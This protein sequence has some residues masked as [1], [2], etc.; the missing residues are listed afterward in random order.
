MCPYIFGTLEL[1]LQTCIPKINLGLEKSLGEKK[2]SLNGFGSDTIFS[3]N[4]YSTDILSLTE[5]IHMHVT[6][7][8]PEA[9]CTFDLL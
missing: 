7:L 9:I 4:H 5:P 6:C 2:K 3:F 1:K 8:K